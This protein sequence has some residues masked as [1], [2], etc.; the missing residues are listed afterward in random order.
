MEERHD[1]IVIGGGQA[2]LAI[3][4][5]LRDRGREHVVLERQR[6]GERWRSERWNS[7][8]FQFPNWSIELP[9]FRYVADDPGGFATAAEILRL[10]AEY[11]TDAPV[12]EHTN[13]IAV[14][15]DGDYFT[16]TTD[17][18]VLRAQHVVIATGPFQRPRIPSIW[19][20]L[21]T[22]ILQTD[23][24]HYRAPESL[25]DGAVLVVGSGASGTQIA[26][27]LLD[28]GRRVFL[29]VSRHR[30]VPRRFRGR[31]VYWWLDRL[32]RFAQTIDSFPDRAWPPST[33]VTG[34]N[35]GYDVDVRRL[36]RAGIQVVGRVLGAVG[37]RVMIAPDANPVL[38]EAD[39]AYRAFVQ[40]ARTYASTVPDELTDDDAVKPL[41]SP[42]PEC[43]EIDLAREGITA[44][45]WATG[46]RYDYG[47]LHVPV[48][49]ERGRP[50]QRRGLTSVPGLY[51]L[52][53]HWMHTFKSGLLSGVGADAE[54]LADR[55][56]DKPSDTRP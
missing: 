14:R 33:V 43:S 8:R 48:L 7:L 17:I 37:G 30:R 31:D 47:W 28:T 9:S 56:S 46:Y 26:D 51:F 38:D 12:R 45:V 53:L 10:L 19:S 40:A 44:V 23:P 54:Y 35:G 24:T 29:A 1:T 50:I 25:P 55:F 22:G 36:A 15:R 11:A 20:D 4:A 16:V 3:S 41:T 21:P 34:V 2:G 27:E 49:D 39:A 13:V 52:G 42:V 32:G 6:V 5:V 18:G